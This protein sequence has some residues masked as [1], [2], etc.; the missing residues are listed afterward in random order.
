MI[1]TN[2]LYKMGIILMKDDKREDNKDNKYNK[3][4]KIKDFLNAPL[5]S[6]TLAALCSTAILSIPT[7]IYKL[8]LLPERIDN[9]EDRI[10]ALETNNLNGT[11]KDSNI[12]IDININKKLR[13][14]KNFTINTN[15]VSVELSCV[16]ANPP[17]SSNDIIVKNEDN[18]EEYTGSQL[19]NQKILLPYRT[20]NEEMYFYG[21][22]N[23]NNQWDGNCIINT[24]RDGNL[25]MI[26]EANYD[27]GNLLD[28]KQVIHFQTLD[29]IKVWSVSERENKDGYT[30][31]DSWNYIFEEEY[32]QNFEFDNVVVDNIIDIEKFKSTINTPLYGF[33]H[34]QTSNGYYND[35]TGQAYYIKYFDNDTFGVDY[36]VIQTLYQGNFVNGKFDDHTYNAWYITRED[37]TTYM[38]YKGCYENGEAF[39]TDSSKDEFINYLTHEQIEEILDKYNFSEYLENFYVE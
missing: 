18:G 34:G 32:K 29:G 22:F 10:I 5:I 21:Q 17:W 25:I 30:C 1:Y 24:Y 38:Y 33:Y 36:P 9:L 39:H 7:G 11:E 19:A 6:A 12:N 23:E 14:L 4:K 37:N 8:A 13:L 28:Y 27:N 16:L 35:T 15:N 2:I 26:M 31:G 20:D 3:L